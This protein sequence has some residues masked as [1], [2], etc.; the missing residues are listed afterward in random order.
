M[1]RP[2]AT[3]RGKRNDWSCKNYS[4]WLLSYE[5]WWI[6]SYPWY[7]WGILLD[8]IFNNVH[9]HH[10]PMWVW[11]MVENFS[12]HPIR[13]IYSQWEF[14]DVV[15]WISLGDAFLQESSHRNVISYWSSGLDMIMLALRCLLDCLNDFLFCRF[16]GC[17]YGVGCCSSGW[18]NLWYWICWK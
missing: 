17:V 7:T 14:L 15:F 5:G 10:P 8:V 3:T 4:F 11:T 18:G 13:F 16:R 9:I 12:V 6:V 2:L 1:H